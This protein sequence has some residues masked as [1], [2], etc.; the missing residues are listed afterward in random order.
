MMNLVN[1]KKLLFISLICA[2]FS[3]TAMGQGRVISQAYE[4]LL[5]NFQAPVSASSTIV[6]KE[7][8]E[9]EA[10]HVRVNETTRYS[11]NGRSVRLEDFRIAVLQASDRENMAVTVLHHL[12]SNTVESIDASI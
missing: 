11:I 10:M 3:A 9:C 1:V 6:F 12:E 7:C 2:F 4:I 5:N 8:D